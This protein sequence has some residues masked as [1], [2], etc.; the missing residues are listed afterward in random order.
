MANTQ[1]DPISFIGF[2]PFGTGLLIVVA[3]GL[4]GY[5]LWGLI[6]AVYDPLRRGN[7]TKGV[8]VRLGYI[9]SA[10]GYGTLLIATIQ[11][12][13]GATMNE[14]GPETWSENLLGHPYGRIAVV[15]IGLG[16]LVGGGLLQI[17]QG[18]KTDSLTPM[19]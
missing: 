13:L 2:N 7:D 6:R 15:I 11:Y 17:Y 18:L 1:T 4:L 9:V 10:F 8:A 5:T 12:I 16:W 19:L 14:N 3:V